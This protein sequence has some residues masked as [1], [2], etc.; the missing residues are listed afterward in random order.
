MTFL[1]RDLYRM[2]NSETIKIC[3][4]QY[5]YFLEFLFTEA[6][7]EIRKDLE[8]V[9]GPHFLQRFINEIFIFV[10]WRYEI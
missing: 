3:Q 9:S 2:C 4:T 6:P 8:L 5:A 1:K 10:I 7:L